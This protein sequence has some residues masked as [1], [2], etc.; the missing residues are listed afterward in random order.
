VIDEVKQ[1]DLVGHP[2][3]WTDLDALSPKTQVDAIEVDP[4]GVTV[5][6]NDFR[7]VANVYVILVYGGGEEP[8]GFTTSEAFLG[9]FKGHFD[10]HQKPIVDEFKVDTSPFY[11]GEEAAG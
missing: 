9:K 3:A 4:A 2:E 10:E 7:G 11:A 8:R 5:S 6:D 1:V